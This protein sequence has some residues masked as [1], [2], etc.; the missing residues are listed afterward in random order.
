M[1]KTRNERKRDMLENIF[2]GLCIV[3]AFLLVITLL[4]GMA[5]KAWVECPAEQP[6]DGREYIAMVQGW[7][8]SK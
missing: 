4:C 7:G 1:S 8:Q 6:I 5:V 2:A 3:F